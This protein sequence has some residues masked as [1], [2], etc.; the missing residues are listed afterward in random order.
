MQVINVVV[1]VVAGAVRTSEADREYRHHAYIIAQLEQQY[2]MTPYRQI[3][4]NIAANL[5]TIHRQQTY[6]ICSK[7]TTEKKVQFQA[8]KRYTPRVHKQKQR[9]K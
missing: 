1:V 3:A 6:T 4:T 7:Y 9:I 5:F 2:R 8:G